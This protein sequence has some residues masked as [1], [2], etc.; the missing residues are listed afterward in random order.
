MVHVAEK[1]ACFFAMDSQAGLPK[2][3]TYSPKTLPTAG[4]V[5][6]VAYVCICVAQACWMALGQFAI[7]PHHIVGIFT[8]WCLHQSPHLRQQPQL[9]FG[10]NG[11]W[12]FIDDRVT[13]DCSRHDGLMIVSTASTRF[14]LVSTHHTE[15]CGRQVH[16]SVR[17]FAAI[18]MIFRI[19]YFYRTPRHA[20]CSRLFKSPSWTWRSSVFVRCSN[21]CHCHGFAMKAFSVV[22]NELSFNVIDAEEVPTITKC[23]VDLRKELCAN[24]WCHTEWK[25]A[26][27]YT[28]FQRFRVHTANGRTIPFERA[29]FA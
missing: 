22:F 19:T 25:V 10:N 1:H 21:Q 16:G 24:S 4:R 8:C 7:K 18:V 17:V 29:L 5:P 20:S 6:H 28:G 26:G 15:Q 2:I 23:D 9:Y 27:Y 14:L 11:C 13:L 12:R 3:F